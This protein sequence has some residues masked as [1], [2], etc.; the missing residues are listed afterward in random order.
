V[1]TFAALLEKMMIPTG[2]ILML[3]YFSS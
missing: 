3:D 1:K 2:Y